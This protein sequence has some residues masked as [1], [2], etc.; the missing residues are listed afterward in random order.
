MGLRAL[1]VRLVLRRAALGPV[2]LIFD[3]APARPPRPL[4]RPAALSV[5]GR[6]LQRLRRKRAAT[7]LALQAMRLAD[8]EE[9]AAS[10]LRARSLPRQLASFV[11]E[12]SSG[13]PSVVIDVAQ[14]LQENGFLQ[15]APAARSSSSSRCGPSSRPTPSARRSAAA[16]TAWRPAAAR[17]EARRRRRRRFTWPEL[18]A[19]HPATKAAYGVVAPHSSGEL[20][21]SPASSPARPAAARAR[22]R[23]ERPPASAP[24]RDVSGRSGAGRGGPA[25]LHHARAH[26]KSEWEFVH[27]TMHET[28]YSLLPVAERRGL[29]RASPSGTSAASPAP[30]SSAPARRRLGR[31]PRRRAA[32]APAASR[33]APGGGERRGGEGRRRFAQTDLALLSHHFLNA[34]STNRPGPTSSRRPA[35]PRPSPSSS[36]GLRRRGQCARAAL[37]AYANVEAS[38]LYED[39]LRVSPQAPPSSAPPGSAPAP[40]PPPLWAASGRGRLFAEAVQCAREGLALL[41][42]PLPS[43]EGAL[44]LRYA[45]L[46]LRLRFTEA[47]TQR[48]SPLAPG[49]PPPSTPASPAVA[50]AAAARQAALAVGHP[51]LPPSPAA[52]RRRRRGPLLGGGGA[53]GV[54]ALLGDDQRAWATHHRR[55]FLYAAA[56]ML[57][58][59]VALAEAGPELA[60]A[61]AAWA[62][63]SGLQQRREAARAW[64]RLA[65]GVAVRLQD[66]EVWSGVVAFVPTA[67][68]ALFS[69]TS[70]LRDSLRASLTLSFVHLRAPRVSADELRAGAQAIRRALEKSARYPDLIEDGE[71]VAAQAAWARAMLALDRA[72]NALDVPGAQG[73]PRG[74]RRLP[75]GV[76][77]ALLAMNGPGARTWTTAAR[78]R[79]RRVRGGGA[80][81]GRGAHFFAVAEPL[82]TAAFLLYTLR[83]ALL[84][85]ERARAHPA[86]PLLE[87]FT[88][89]PRSRAPSAARRAQQ[90]AGRRGRHS[91]RGTGPVSRRSSSPPAADAGALLAALE[92]AAR[93]L[94]ALDGFGLVRPLAAYARGL[95]HSARGRPCGGA[96]GWCA[97]RGQGDGTSLHGGSV[98]A[99]VRQRRR[100]R[101][102]GAGG[103]GRRGSRWR[104]CSG[105]CGRA[106]HPRDE[107]LALLFAALHAPRAPRPAP[108]AP[109]AAAALYAVRERLAPVSAASSGDLLL[110]SGD[111]STPSPKGGARPAA[112]RAPA[113]A[114]GG[115]GG[116]RLLGRAEGASRRAATS[117]WRAPPAASPPSS[118]AAPPRAPRPAPR[119]P[120]GGLG[121]G[122]L[123]GEEPWAAAGD[124][125]PSQRQPAGPSPADPAAAA[126]AVRR[127]SDAPSAAPSDASELVPELE[128]A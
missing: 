84:P 34:G 77:A 22:R 100:G 50:A 29:H 23:F 125:R 101:R 69:R 89:G 81:G 3:G 43:G 8:A 53:G 35:P 122:G 20:A 93:R 5:A 128:L 18:L 91:L 118:R 58:L 68:L 27:A 44:A 72:P 104:R 98:W 75:R 121:R 70:S 17:P 109:P 65:W 51:L 21:A 86:H 90:A 83:L 113:A 120:P 45:L 60:A 19:I 37:E 88:E 97:T 102:V 41:G 31:R 73:G 87:L 126:A 123:G 30:C 38:R 124:A 28:T 11:Y 33:P 114:G 40:T 54:P 74:A 26:A 107:G 55:L 71:R 49:P 95:L 16:W 59:A 92:R 52:V 119:R 24:P 36:S 32:L 96:G 103:R 111:A 110:A 13:I 48:P 112:A 108:P 2:V 4:A 15:V 10:V 14:A 63:V 66:A 115:D 9:L 39:L 99:A 105:G 6:A 85:V 80:G 12:Q 1:I 64:A 42:H 76:R 106:R 61:A 47:P 78:R 94:A 25:G 127:P 56:R 57:D 7:T 79:G 67:M 117:T 46:E 62:A 116:G 82:A